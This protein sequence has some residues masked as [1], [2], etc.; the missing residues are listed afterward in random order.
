MPVN[1][2]VL[3]VDGT[4]ATCPYDFEAMRAA[5]AEIAARWRLEARQLGLRGVIEQINH[6]SHALG[7]DGPA[8]RREAEAAVTAIEVAAARNA[9]ILPGAAQALAELRASGVAVAL[10]TRNCRPASDTVLRGFEDYAILLTRDDVP[11]AK[12]DPDHVLRALAAVRG[13]PE[14]AAVVGDHAY[15]MEAGR[16][17]GVR[18]C[19]GVRTGASSDQSLIEAGAEAVID[20]IA[21]LP[22]WLRE[23]GELPARGGVEGPP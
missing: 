9:A 18:L 16:A 14:T 1:A 11:S 21:E 2:A 6:I 8:F 19:I 7:S 15:D 17:A 12:P 13:R 10:I 23:R 20:S 22:R 3:D 4:V 5:I